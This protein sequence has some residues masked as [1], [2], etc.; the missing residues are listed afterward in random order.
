[1]SCIEDICSVSMTFKNPSCG[2][3]PTLTLYL[4]IYLYLT[5]NNLF[6]IKNAKN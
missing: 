4:P 1:M 5:M 3:Y 6:F 2:L